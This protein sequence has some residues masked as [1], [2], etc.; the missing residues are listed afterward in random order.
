MYKIQTFCDN[1]D[2]FLKSQKSKIQLIFGAKIQI[3]SRNTIGKLPS[4][5]RAK[6]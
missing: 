3:F 4:N 2:N 1:L 5:F 6:N